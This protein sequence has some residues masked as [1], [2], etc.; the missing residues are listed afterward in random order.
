MPRGDRRGPEGMGPMT[1]RRAGFCS[2][3][4]R[5]GYMYSGEANGSPRF[6][7][8]RGAGMGRGAGAG[9][10]RNYGVY[11]PSETFV[12]ERYSEKD[13]LKQEITVLKDQLEVLEQRLSEQDNKA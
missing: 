3:A 4:G 6:S 2:G 7:G 12:D 5:P 1:G 9:Y 11:P 13:F 10:G 8:R